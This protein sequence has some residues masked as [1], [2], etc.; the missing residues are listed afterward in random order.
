MMVPTVEALFSRLQWRLDELR[1]S[2]PVAGARNLTPQHRLVTE[3]TR[4][5]YE[6]EQPWALGGKAR[7]IGGARQYE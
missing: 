7:R 5:Q 1:E 2:A 3:K 6:L 4:D